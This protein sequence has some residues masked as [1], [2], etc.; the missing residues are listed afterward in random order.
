[1]QEDPLVLSIFI[2]FS[3]TALFA[4]LALYTRQSLLV[5]YILLGVLFGPWCLK[6][7][8]DA[9]VINHIGEVGITLLLF[10]L[11]LDLNP[12]DLFVMFRSAT[13]VTV[14][15]AVIFAAVGYA[16]GLLFHFTQIESLVIGGAMMFSSTIIGLKLLPSAILHHQH[17]GRV[18]IGVLLLQDMLAILTLIFINA[19]ISDG[20]LDWRDGLTVGV[21][22]PCLIAFAFIVE[23][24]ILRRIILRFEHIKE[25]IFLVAIGWCLGMGELAK[26]AGLTQGIGAFIAGVSIAESSPIALYIADHL[27]PLR[28]FF[29]VMFFF[30]IGAS[31]NFHYLKF[32]WLP[33]GILTIVMLIIKPGIFSLLL[34][35]VGEQTS[36]AQEMGVRLGQNS[37]FALLLAYMAMTATPALISP[38]ASYL[39]GAVT[40]FTFMA[41]CYYIVWRYPTPMGLTHN[42]RRD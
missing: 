3:G 2:I 4:T 35:Y 27:K 5:A 1:M 29:L 18:V 6:L 23:R 22:L 9:A 10:L 25:Y 17:I 33:V 32:I 14:T 15:S 40:I 34:R 21:W 20:G 38:K 7:V 19:A 37:E 8:A 42:L 30:S 12:K 41:S 31:F 13:L 24:F 26:V 28:D 36:V 11:G 16:V 39:I